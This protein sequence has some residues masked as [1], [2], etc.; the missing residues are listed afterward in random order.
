MQELKSGDPFYLVGALISIGKHFLHQYRPLVQSALSH[1]DSE[2][3]AEALRVLTFYWHDP[4]YEVIA[5]Q[6]ID[7]E[8]EEYNREIALS[9]WAS[10]YRATGNV[11]I[12]QELAHFIADHG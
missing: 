4:H 9:C 5:H 6:W 8:Q 1:K 3:R 2:V 7:E 10:Y 12:L 11:E